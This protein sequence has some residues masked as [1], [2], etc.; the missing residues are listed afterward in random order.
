MQVVGAS[1]I[2]IRT[3]SNLALS[4]S[5]AW[6][7][8]SNL[9]IAHGFG[10][11]TWGRSQAWSLLPPVFG[12]LYLYPMSPRHDSA[13]TAP[14]LFAFALQCSDLYTRSDHSPASREVQRIIDR[15]L[16]L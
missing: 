11:L 7:T 2:V 8:R 14:Q 12:L 10:V 3:S 16:P 4:V 1:S 5:C 6:G 9:V 15:P 13:M